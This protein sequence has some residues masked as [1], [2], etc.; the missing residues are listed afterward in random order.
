MQICPDFAHL[1]GVRQILPVSR[2]AWN[3]TDFEHAACA[4]TLTHFTFNERHL[5]HDTVFNCVG[6]IVRLHVVTRLLGRWM[7][8]D[9]MY[10]IRQQRGC[11]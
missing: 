6:A 3:G 7:L 4:C 8:M 5:S 2:N 1:E 9:A 10:F 11:R